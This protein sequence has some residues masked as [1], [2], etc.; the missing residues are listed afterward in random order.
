MMHIFRIFL[1]LTAFL[2]AVLF[3]RDGRG[4]Y[5][6]N[7]QL[8]EKLGFLV[9]RQMATS[10]FLSF[11]THSWLYSVRQAEPQRAFGWEFSELPE[12]EIVRCLQ[13]LKEA[14]ELFCF[15]WST[16]TRFFGLS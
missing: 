16:I 12:V 8:H 3:V 9:H 1:K 2:L 10:A 15:S 11:P 7:F 4:A 6:S 5:A 14:Q 13:I